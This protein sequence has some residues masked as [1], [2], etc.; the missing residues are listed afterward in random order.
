M[1]HAYYC[2]LN[3]IYLLLESVFKFHQEHFMQ[4]H[5]VRIFCGLKITHVNVTDTLMQSISR[6]TGMNLQIPQVFPSPFV[7]P[8]LLPRS[9]PVDPLLNCC[10]LTSRFF[11]L[12]SFVSIFS[13]YLFYISCVVLD[14]ITLIK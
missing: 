4:T 7:C 2:I 8:M 13:Y 1:L 12:Y 11:S 10:A 6:F 5:E 3:C 14:E 9:W